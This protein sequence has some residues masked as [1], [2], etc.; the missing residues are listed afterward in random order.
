MK[1]KKTILVT[2]AIASMMS[3]SNEEVIDIQ[4]KQAITFDNAFVE[5]APGTR[6]AYDG[7]YTT[8]SLTQFQVYGTITNTS[9]ATG[10]VF[11]GE[12]VENQ[13]GTWTLDGATQYWIPGNTYHF[14]AIADGNVANATSVDAGEKNCEPQTITVDASQQKDVLLATRTFENY[15][16]TDGTVVEF[17]FNHLMAKAKFT[18][19]NTVNTDNGYNYVVSGIQIKTDKKGVYDVANKTWSLAEDS[20]SYYLSFGNAVAEGT[21]AGAE[22][23]AIGFNSQAESNYDRLLIP[24]DYLAAGSKNLTVTFTCVTRIGTT[25]L[26]T[27][28]KEVTTQKD[29]VLE[30]GKAYNFIISLGNPGEK[31]Q[32]TVNE[33]SGWIN[34]NPGVEIK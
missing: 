24:N 14:W 6:A 11:T 16:T 1:M 26:R 19:K 25:V 7:S 31:I 10:R 23:T 2:L 33:V 5:K 20:E 13:S 34:N 32:F 21:E 22:A 27:E 28:T 4:A 3:C 8:S 29:V 9:D 30:K 15:Q 18:V 12:V 17:T